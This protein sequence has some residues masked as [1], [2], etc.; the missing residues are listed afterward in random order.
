MNNRWI[1]GNKIIRIPVEIMEDKKTPTRKD[2]SSFRKLLLILM[3]KFRD[4]IND[5]CQYSGNR[6][7]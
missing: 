7:R 3:E 2:E 4:V 1:C 6:N 5:R